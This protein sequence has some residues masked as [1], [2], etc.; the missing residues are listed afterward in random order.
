MNSH[1]IEVAFQTF[2][3]LFNAFSN[4]CNTIYIPLHSQHLARFRKLQFLPSLMVMQSVS[5]SS[6]TFTYDVDLQ[7]QLA[8]SKFVSLSTLECFSACTA[9]DKLLFYT[10]VFH[11]ALLE[12]FL[13]DQSEDLSSLPAIVINKPS[14]SRNLLDAFN[15]CSLQQSQQSGF[16]E[17]GK[18][19]QKW[20]DF[21]FS[22]SHV[23]H[24]K[25][26]TLS[27]EA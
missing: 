1:Q 7:I 9:V 16:S 27:N 6:I 15:S 12:G 25:R 13:S 2:L 19:Q 18:E 4:D 3:H 10:M 11:P 21:L 22:P 14:C 24:K 8:W 5:V 26:K 20:R 17:G 23:S